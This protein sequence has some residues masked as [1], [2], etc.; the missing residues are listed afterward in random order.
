MYFLQEINVG[1]PSFVPMELEGLRESGFFTLIM[2]LLPLEL[3]AMSETATAL[4][5]RAHIVKKIGV[6]S[7]HHTF[8]PPSS[9]QHPILSFAGA[10][11]ASMLRDGFCAKQVCS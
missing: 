11:M 4:V 7:S 6:F 10:S 8:G 5:M 2:D 3:L 1:A 9:L